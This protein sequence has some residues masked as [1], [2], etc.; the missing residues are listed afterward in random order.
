MLNR[1]YQEWPKRMSM[2]RGFLLTD[3]FSTV[4]SSLFHCPAADG[5]QP[6]STETPNPEEKQR[7]SP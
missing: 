3:E 2:C 5:R 4:D 7:K 6:E 1:R